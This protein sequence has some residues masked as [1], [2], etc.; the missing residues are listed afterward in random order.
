MVTK[1]RDAT[2]RG[3]TIVLTEDVEANEPNSLGPHLVLEE[4]E[5]INDCSSRWLLLIGAEVLRSQIVAKRSF[6]R[7]Q[8]FKI[9]FDGCIFQ[10][11]FADC[12]FGHRGSGQNFGTI[13]DVKACDFTQAK[14]QD[15]SFSNCKIERSQL[16]GWPHYTIP[17]PHERA[18]D[19]MMPG[20]PGRLGLGFKVDAEG[21][22]GIVA[23][24]YYAPV[25][26]KRCRIT[27]DELRRALEKLGGVW[28]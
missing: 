14:L 19:L 5:L 23:V 16:P 6:E 25:V 20:W 9:A 28:M 26:A 15:C 8:F 13:G 11:R 4:C 22:E 27:E 24:C 3:Q 18:K 2:I 7:Q 21:P 17:N 12:E 1:L 10:G